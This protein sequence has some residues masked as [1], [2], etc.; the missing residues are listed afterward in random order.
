V[1]FEAR[2]EEE[3][4]ADRRT[5][6]RRTLRL[7]ADGQFAAGT[8]AVTVHNI[9]TTG[10]MIQT[11][12]QMSEGDLFALDLP[13]AG[14]QVAEVVWANA[15]MFGCRFAHA[16]S[17]AAV[18]AT[19]L[20]GEAAHARPALAAD[21]GFGV[22]LHRLRTERGMSLADIAARLG[23]SKPTVWAWEH[24]KS[25]P[26]EKRLAGL[27]EALGVT[28]GGLQPAPSGPPEVLER[29]RRQIAEAWGVEA[30]QVRIMIEL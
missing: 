11:A 19:Q 18:S 26:V 6:P 23:V 21:E 16:V 10:M 13:E 30:R 25:R 28:P 17:P 8:S 4:A 15:P 1:T 24:G 20:R 14:D 27:A 2:F 29:S 22:R 12:T 3:S 9:S 5:A 7:G